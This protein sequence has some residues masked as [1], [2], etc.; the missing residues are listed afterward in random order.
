[1]DGVCL[2]LHGAQLLEN[3]SFAVQPGEVLTILGPNGAGK[4]TLLRVLSGEWAPADGEVSF[5][6]RPIHQWRAAER[7]RAMAVLPQGATLDFPFTCEEVVMLGRTPHDSGQQR[8]GEIVG[9][10]LA[11]VDGSHLRS[12][13]YTQL[14]GGEKQRVQ[15]A[16]VLAQIWE[17]VAGQSR[18][19]IL[20]EPTASFDLAHQQL[21]LDLV[22]QLAGQGFGVV[23][24][25]HDLNMAA[26]CATR[27]LLIDCGR[28]VEYGPPMAVLTPDNIQRVFGVSAVVQTNPL[29][30]NPLVIT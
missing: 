7:A 9:E 4:S 25:L 29:T 27:M 26:R 17:P 20:D 15:L 2:R 28:M 24:V 3:V 23:M 18:I 12:R 6:G 19:L 1:M 30:G 8:D 13:I 14:S 22:Q 11:A 21:T 10:A 5:N 16:R